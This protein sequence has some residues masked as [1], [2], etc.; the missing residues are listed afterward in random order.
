MNRINPLTRKVI[1]SIIIVSA[2]VHLL[3]LFLAH[4]LLN[5]WRWQQVPFH[6]TIEVAGSVIAFFVVYML[7]TLEV[8]NKGTS[9][10]YVIASALVAMGILDAI[11]AMVPVGQLFVWLHSSA[12]FFGGLFF[13]MLYLPQ[14]WLIKLNNKWLLFVVLFTL[15]YAALSMAFAEM[16]PIMADDNGF[17]QTAIVLNVSGGVALIAAAI[18]LFLSYRSRGKTDDLLFVLHCTMF[19]LA[20]IMFQQSMLWDI[21]WWGWH[22]LRFFAYGVA[23]WFA[24]ANE[25]MINAQ[26]AAARD[27]LNVEVEHT[28]AQLSDAAKQL[29]ITQA[30]QYAVYKHLTD[31]IV[32]CD[33]NGMIK[34]FS[35]SAERLFERCSEQVLGTDIRSLVSQQHGQADVLAREFFGVSREFSTDTASTQAL[36]LELVITQVELEGEINLLIVVREISAR[37]S[38]EQELKAAKEQADSANQAKSAFLANTSHE[39]RTPMN[40]VY[41]NL[42]L[43]ANEE[44]SSQA[45][46]YLDNAIYSS[47]SLMTVINDILDISKVE[48]GAMQIENVTFNL[49]ELI[50]NTLT[51]TNQAAKKKAISFQSINNIEHDSWL[52]DP[53]R[54]RQVL[55]NIISN[56][57]KF[58]KSGAVV[59]AISYL[60]KVRQLVVIVTDTGIGMSPEA[61]DKLFVRFEQADSSI[62]RDYG[63]TGIGMSITYALVKLMGGNIEV[64]S[65][66]GHGSTFTV[67]IPLEKVC[68]QANIEACTDVTS[69]EAEQAQLD[70]TGINI[71]VA[72]DNR[73]N[74]AIAKAMLTETGANIHIA[75]NGLE[76]ISIAQQHKPSL[77]L[78]DIQMPELD[79]ISA[80]KQLKTQFDGLP[81]IAFTANVMT[82]DIQSYQQAGF[83]GYLGKPLE[84]QQLLATIAKFC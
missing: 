38:Y 8:K 82:Y 20:A 61:L 33:P 32:V 37:K 50:A 72:E 28:S 21:S 58:T 9:F 4:T 3:S 79:G 5:Y 59:V 30:Q 19:G 40:G 27:K 11:H 84:R 56:A 31:G 35:S 66:Q 7:L 25:S 57:I 26:I 76:A 70:L 18:K 17:S 71:L 10:N 55:L 39:I 80:C 29:K 83:D 68:S 52:G 16:L 15:C 65:E 45:K 36:P 12:T 73:I 43:L 81:I 49:P 24:L 47:K 53:V 44:L 34:F 69:E 51:E 1:V 74:Q 41:G 46:G 77:V 63:G 64:A 60:E 67:R 6:S 23:L 14:R 42:Q 48:A 78:M 13:L 22:L 54:I 75:N 2:L 62:T